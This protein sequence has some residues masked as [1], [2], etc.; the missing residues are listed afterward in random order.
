MK[1]NSTCMVFEDFLKSIPNGEQARIIGIHSPERSSR[2]YH[3]EIEVRMMYSGEKKSFYI[4]AGAMMTVQIGAL[5]RN[6]RVTLLETLE[7]SDARKSEDNFAHKYPQMKL[8]R[9]MK[10]SELPDQAKVPNGYI[11]WVFMKDEFCFFTEQG[12]IYFVFPCVEYINALCMLSTEFAV[13]FCRGEKMESICTSTRYISDEDYFLMHFNRTIKRRVAQDYE[14]FCYEYPRFLDRYNSTQNLYRATGKLIGQVEPINTSAYT[15]FGV[16]LSEHVVLI[17]TLQYYDDAPKK[18][19]NIRY[20]PRTVKKQKQQTS[21]AKTQK[22]K[23]PLEVG[24]DTSR[25]QTVAAEDKKTSGR[26]HPK[27]AETGRKPIMNRARQSVMACKQEINNNDSLLI[28][29]LMISSPFALDIPSLEENDDE[30]SEDEK[31]VSSGTAQSVD[32]TQI[33]NIPQE[34]FEEFKSML[35]TLPSLGADIGSVMYFEQSK[36]YGPPRDCAVVRIRYGS[37][38]YDIFEVKRTHQMATLIQGKTAK[39]L[40]NDSPLIGEFKDIFSK[41]GTWNNNLPANYARLCHRDGRTS[42]Q[43]ATRLIDKI[44]KEVH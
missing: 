19:S 25:V 28:K 34:G 11:D 13:W 32:T 31:R 6:G 27:Q 15:F 42:K 12:G 1:N 44:K 43:W 20:T 10:F 22:Q 16:A 4:R 39:L 9:V 29:K 30:S 3:C 8:S 2:G 41:T 14:Y 5:I 33:D 35:R 18:Y 38:I 21:D 40:P 17:T 24:E 7:E 37:R 23:T 36:L 26:G